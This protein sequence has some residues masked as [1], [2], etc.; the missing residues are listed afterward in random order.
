MK[1]VNNV[2]EVALC[3]AHYINSKWSPEPVMN[4]VLPGVPTITLEIV[5][6]KFF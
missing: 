5:P 2:G 6:K 3:K 4:A 1:G